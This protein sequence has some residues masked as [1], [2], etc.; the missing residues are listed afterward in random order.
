M[1]GVALS[2][3]SLYH[4]GKGVRLSCTPAGCECSAWRGAGGAR[5]A[6][7][8]GAR[9]EWSGALRRAGADVAHGMRVKVADALLTRALKKNVLTRN[10]TG[11]V[12]ATKRSTDLYTIKTFVADLRQKS[13]ICSQATVMLQGGAAR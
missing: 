12:A 8:C 7:L 3:S 10:R 2:L 1:C 5:F 4:V 11:V 13:S 6:L 9:R